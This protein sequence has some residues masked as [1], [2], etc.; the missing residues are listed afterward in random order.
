V[1]LER[2]F[3]RWLILLG[4]VAVVVPASY[5]IAG[6]GFDQRLSASHSA[7]GLGELVAALQAGVGIVG[8]SLY[9]P[10]TAAREPIALMLGISVIVAQVAATIYA[11]RLPSRERPRFIV[12]LTLTLYSWLVVLEIIG[13]RLHE[14]GV[15]FTPRYSMFGLYAPVSLLFWF[16]SMAD[17]FRWKK[18]FGVYALIVIAVGVGFADAQ[19]S[20]RLPYVRAALDRARTTLLSLH[21]TPTPQQRAIMFVNAPLLDLVYPDL[22]FLRQQ[23]LAMYEG[24]EAPAPHT[25]SVVAYGPTKIKAGTP[26]NV[27]PDG[28]SAIWIETNPATVGEVYIVINSARLAAY[29]RD[30]VVT[31]TVPAFLYKKPGV[32]KMYV[33]ETTQDSSTKSQPVDFIVH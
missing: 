17:A 12:P 16:V 14:P 32:Y 1:L 5:V 4:I 33:L 29:H 8:N 15:A 9:S 13:A 23:H 10:L 11:L 31:A 20:Q 28:S 3:D 27:Q 30:N 24:E 26:F 19:T 6:G 2:R 21:G 7:F 18:V 22:Q 25:L